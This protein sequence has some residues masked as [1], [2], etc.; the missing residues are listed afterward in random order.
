M[1]KVGANEGADAL[2]QMA[3]AAMKP[4]KAMPMHWPALHVLTLLLVW[5]SFVWAGFVW[6]SFAAAAQAQPGAPVQPAAVQAALETPDT[7]V[8]SGVTS[9]DLH[10]PKLF[11][12]SNPACNAATAGDPVTIQRVRTTGSPARTLFSRNDPR[13]PSVCNPYAV[14]SNVVA[15]D[16]YV[17]WLDAAG[18]QRLSAAANPGDAPQQ[19]LAASWSTTDPMQL[20]LGPNAVYAYTAKRI[21]SAAKSGPGSGS[22]LFVSSDQPSQLAY[23]D[24][25]L[26]YIAAGNLYR[27]ELASNTRLTVDPSGQVTAYA[28]LSN[29]TQRW[30]F[31]AEGLYVYAYDLIANDWIYPQQTASGKAPARTIFYTAGDAQAINPRIGAM[32]ASVA[33]QVASLFVF[34]K[35]QANCGQPTCPIYNHL[36]RVPIKYVNALG[37]T[38]DIPLSLYVYDTAGNNSV[39]AAP[40][41]NLSTDNTFLYFQLAGAL[42]RLP[43]NAATLPKINLRPTGLEI[44][45]GIQNGDNSIVLVQSRDTF[46][47]VYVKSDG[48]TVQDVTAQLSAS[49]SGMANAGPILSTNPRIAVQATPNNLDYNQQ[50][51]FQLP[52]EWTQHADLRLTFQLNPYGVPLEPDYADNVLTAGPYTFQPSPQLNLAFAQF[53]Y[54]LNGSTYAPQGL[55]NNVA[56]IEQA[57]PLGFTLQNGDWLPGLNYSVWDIGDAGGALAR[58]VAHSSPECDA[59]ILRNPNGSVKRDDSE[60]CAGDYANSQLAALHSARSLAGATFIYGMIPDSGVGSQFPRGQAGSDTVSSGPDAAGWDGFYAGHEVGHT[61]GAAHPLTGNGECGLAGSDSI[62]PYLRARIGPENSSVN[63]FWPRWLSLGGRWQ[64]GAILRGS[65]WTDLM[66]YCR[67]TDWPRQWISDGNYTRFY[68]SIPQPAPTAGAAAARTQALAGDYLS[69][70]GSVAPDGSAASLTLVRRQSTA[71]NIPPLAAGPFA[72]RLYNA[73]N[74]VLAEYPF[75]PDG[76]ADGWLP[77]GQVVD[78]VA[79]TTRVELVRLADNRALAMTVVSPRPPVVHS[80]SQPQVTGGNVALSWSASDPDGDVLSYDILYSRDGGATFQPV[81]FGVRALSAT[82]DA[83]KLGGST[84]ALFQVIANDG[85]NSAYA[86]SPTFAMPAKPPLVQIRTPADGIRVH[87]RQLVNFS[88]SALDFQD[89][90]L[91]G[92]RLTWSSQAGPLGSG[93]LLS[94]DNLPVGV[95]TITLRATNSAGLTSSASVTVVVDDDLSVEG[96]NLSVEPPSV[97]WSVAAGVAAMQTMTLS[98]AN[99]G[100]GSITWQAASNQSWLTLSMTQGGIGVQPKVSAVPAGL[101]VG[102]N[103]A[104]ITF[105]AIEPS[106]GNVVQTVN[107]PVNLWIGDPGYRVVGPGNTTS[108]ASLYLPLLRR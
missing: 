73:G 106:T 78:F 93:A 44:T 7:L 77:F 108:K 29:S 101:P 90:Q 88:G 49:W 100:G 47:R 57:Y 40:R 63:G 60:F 66:A 81:Q 26:Y 37:W 91:A 14:L 85:V 31:V 25:W 9:F 94:L 34:E 79:G 84:A 99:V 76:S 87:W 1:S 64:L 19:L 54:S 97:A 43:I 52:Y 42:L 8:A 13:D 104:V 69:V 71:D 67:R 33:N 59:Y 24:G 56:W 61:L 11:W 4:R 30:V 107:V 70:Y 58:R 3:G 18:L 12:A 28:Y 2:G 86:N 72:I 102:V 6:A 103:Q 51:I 55:L 75:T 62:P 53:S 23:H 10:S 5:A 96:P 21:W 83:S 35:R 20:T 50:F 89:G 16:Q 22:P 46:V 27:Y 38:G 41:S 98:L 105:Y 17:Y 95:N 74:A 80:V 45:Q 82:I 92:A 48:S 32:T 36:Q 15:D 65:D 68:N 39:D